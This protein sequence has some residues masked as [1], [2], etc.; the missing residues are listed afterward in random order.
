MSTVDA[1]G[2]RI[3]TDSDRRADAFGPT[4]QLRLNSFQHAH[5]EHSRQIGFDML[6]SEPE[7][8]IGGRHRRTTRRH[9]RHRCE[10]HTDR[11]TGNGARARQFTESLQQRISD[12]L[13]V[14]GIGDAQLLTHQSIEIAAAPRR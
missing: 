4:G 11:F 9:R 13:G 8:E 6:Q 12:H 1:H 14:I 10:R 7:I 2:N 3:L 5:S